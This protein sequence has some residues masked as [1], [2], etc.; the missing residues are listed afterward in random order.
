M[1][2]AGMT[3]LAKSVVSSVKTHSVINSLLILV[4]IVALPSMAILPFVHGMKAYFYAGLIGFVICAAI[5]AYAYFSVKNPDYLRSETYQLKH[6]QL[7][8]GRKGK[9]FMPEDEPVG[10]PAPD[11][12]TTQRSLPPPKPEGSA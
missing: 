1:I 10:L 7:E 12:E 2:D 11:T 5:F 4:A 3:G 8:L 9:L 6:Q